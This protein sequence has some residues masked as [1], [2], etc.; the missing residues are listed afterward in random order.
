MYRATIKGIGVLISYC[1]DPQ[2]MAMELLNKVK[3]YLEGWKISNNDFELVQRE[4]FAL[5]G[6]IMV[7]E[8][9]EC[10]KDQNQRKLFFNAILDYTISQ[11]RFANQI[12][13]NYYLLPLYLL[14][15]F[16]NQTYPL[17]KNKFEN[18]LIDS[19]DDLVIVLK[20]LSSNE[21]QI[22]KK[23]QTKLTKRID[24]ELSF[25]KQLLLQKNQAKE[26]EDIELMVDRVKKTVS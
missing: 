7:L 10:F 12:E 6:I 25:I 11:M 15:L 21:Y 5:C 8:H 1:E 14:S 19:V 9:K 23:S 18:E 4:S 2:D 26:V 24:N 3:V 17:F 16:A 22:S 20:V 13:N